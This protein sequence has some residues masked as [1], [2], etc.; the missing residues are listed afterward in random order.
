MFKSVFIYLYA[1]LML[2]DR[3]KVR[4][5]SSD[6]SVFY[7]TLTSLAVGL[8]AAFVLPE[9]LGMSILFAFMWYIY[10]RKEFLCH[11]YESLT[12]NDHDHV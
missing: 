4:H 2:V 1:F 9:K 12:E 8:A 11:Y 7:S 3:D 6:S 10:C 5:V